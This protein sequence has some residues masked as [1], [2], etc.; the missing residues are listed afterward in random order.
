MANSQTPLTPREEATL[1]RVGAVVGGTE[2]KRRSD[3]LSAL[4]EAGYPESEADSLLDRLLSK[5]YVYLVD[6]ELHVT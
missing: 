1:E 5:G 2:S 6:D 4:A 3:V